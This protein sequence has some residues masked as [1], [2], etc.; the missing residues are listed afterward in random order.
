[1]EALAPLNPSARLPCTLA[2]PGP[3]QGLCLWRLQGPLVSGLLRYLS[4]CPEG[5]S[6]SQWVSGCPSFLRQ[7]F[8]CS[9][10]WMDHLLF[11]RY[12]WLDTW[13]G[14]AFAAVNEPPSSAVFLL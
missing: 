5:S 12:L 3:S 14:S 1:M 4:L 11:I 9:L 6:V 7:N 8:V 10:V 2:R 13:V